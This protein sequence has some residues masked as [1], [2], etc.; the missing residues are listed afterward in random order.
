MD[1]LKLNEECEFNYFMNQMSEATQYSYNLYHSMIYLDRVYLAD[2][3]FSKFRGLP[4][5]LFGMHQA[6]SD[7]LQFLK[8]SSALI[9]AYNHGL[10]TIG[11]ND[12]CPHFGAGFDP[13]Q[14]QE[15]RILSQTNFEL[16][17]IYNSLFNADALKNV[18]GP[19]LWVNIQNDS[20]LNWFMNQLGIQTEGINLNPQSNFCLEVAEIFGCKP[21]IDFNENRS[22]LSQESKMAFPRIAYDFINGVHSEIQQCQIPKVTQDQIHGVLEKWSKSLEAG[23]HIIYD[24]LDYL[25]PIRDKHLI[26]QEPIPE[27]LTQ[28]L[29]QLT[30]KWEKELIYL[31]FIKKYREFFYKISTGETNIPG[32]SLESLD[33]EQQNLVDLQYRIALYDFLKQQV[34]VHLHNCKK[35]ILAIK[36]RPADKERELIIEPESP[37]A[38][39]RTYEFSEQEYIIVDSELGVDFRETFDD[40]KHKPPLCKKE[41][42]PNGAVKSEIYLRNELRHGPSSFYDPAGQLLAKGW[43]VENK[44]TGINRQYYATGQI[45]SEQK[46]RAGLLEGTQKYYY[47]QG[48]LKTV[49]SYKRGKLEGE[50]SLYYPSSQLKRRLN[51]KEG[52]R[53]GAEEMWYPNGDKELEAEFE[54]DQPVGTVK[55]WYLHDRPAKQIIFHKPSN[56]FDMTFWNEEGQVIKSLSSKPT[57]SIDYLIARTLELKHL[58]D[59]TTLKLTELFDKKKDAKHD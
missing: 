17:F 39:K 19:R 10:N 18:H 5:L 9:F 44:Q 45:Y 26:I 29:I 38:F 57:D 25:T 20:L 7:V 12:I 24:V 14:N 49:M 58:L 4:A 33:K 42:Y 53:H 40:T 55:N 52:K 31:P 15:L 59:E 28:I 36:T 47:P 56:E 46:Y 35:A 37:S 51:F 21:V 41:Y 43:F 3:L 54:N 8:N 1:R 2:H 22:N 23:L 50:V 16:P 34:G 13:S 48:V 6:N 30:Q 27:D 11:H 32:L